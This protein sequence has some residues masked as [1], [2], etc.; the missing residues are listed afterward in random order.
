[1]N[2]AWPTRGAQ[3]AGVMTCPR[4]PRAFPVVG[5]ALMVAVEARL[6]EFDPA[7][8]QGVDLLFGVEPAVTAGT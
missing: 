2:G 4:M 5:G 1:M 3:P 7:G 8:L 6:D